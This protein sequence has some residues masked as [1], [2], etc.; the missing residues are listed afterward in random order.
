MPSNLL[1]S[2]A[3]PRYRSAVYGKRYIQ[4]E[5]VQIL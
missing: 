4:Y 2:V 5:K 1:P 3:G